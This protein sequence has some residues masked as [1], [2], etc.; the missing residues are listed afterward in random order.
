[1]GTGEQETAVSDGA[2]SFKGSPPRAAPGE[3]V[4]QKNSP[5]V[6]SADGDSPMFNYVE[7]T[8]YEYKT[9]PSGESQ[10][11]SSMKTTPVANTT[12]RRDSSWTKSS[13][14]DDIASSSEILWGGKDTAP[15]GKDG[16]RVSLAA[17]LKD[18]S[19][20]CGVENGIA[21]S[22]APR[23]EPE[24]DRATQSQSMKSSSSKGLPE[25]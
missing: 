1:M 21:S 7:E 6:A 8:V 25:G 14:H 18:A 10:T 22:G 11:T 3:V 9:T 24:G 15:Y 20:E 12:V 4:S 19:K 17:R 5:E 2:Y 13:N 23:G 16:P